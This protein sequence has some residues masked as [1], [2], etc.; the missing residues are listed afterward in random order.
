MERP[1]QIMN[2]SGSVRTIDVENRFSCGHLMN[3]D[4]DINKIHVQCTFF[5]KRK[6]YCKDIQYTKCRIDFCL[7]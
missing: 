7:G 4:Y 2:E 5:F 3:F 6:Q 1:N